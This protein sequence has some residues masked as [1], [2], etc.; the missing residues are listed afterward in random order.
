MVYGRVL[1]FS[2]YERLPI[3]RIRRFRQRTGGNDYS[4]GVAVDSVGNVYITGDTSGA[5]AGSNAGNVDA[6]LV[7][8]R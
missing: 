2:F 5:L 7:K 6:W 1:V 3:H 4:Y 8:Y